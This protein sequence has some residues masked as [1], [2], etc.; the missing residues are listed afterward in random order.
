MIGNIPIVS[1]VEPFA[2]QQV[3][4]FDPFHAQLPRE[5]TAYPDL[6]NYFVF[7]LHNN[8]SIVLFCN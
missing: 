8:F 7:I 3:H 1:T 5:L 2:N 4:N 6:R